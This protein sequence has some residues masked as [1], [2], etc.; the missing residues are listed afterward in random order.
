MWKELIEVF[1]IS[2]FIL[3]A[4]AWVVRSLFLRFLTKDIEK[5]KNDLKREADKEFA[6]IESQ[7]K[8]DA[9]THQIR[10]SRL[11]ECRAEIIAELYKKIVALESARLCLETE[12]ETEFER[13]DNSEL[14]GKA[15]K[16]IDKYYE[17]NEYIENNKIYFPESLSDK[18]TDYGTQYFNLSIEIVYLSKADNRQTLIDNFQKD[19]EDFRNRNEKIKNIIES[20]FRKLLGV[21]G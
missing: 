14:E 18:L 2:A 3:A 19:K 7:L 11:H 21:I 6:K 8:I 10:F 1:G 17:V 4:V 15:D 5:Y 20:D 9:L 12:F 13:E 16:F